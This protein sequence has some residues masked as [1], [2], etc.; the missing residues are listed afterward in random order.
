MDTAPQLRPTAA[1]TLCQT[2]FGKDPYDGFKTRMSKPDLQGWN[3][4]HGRL[5]WLVRQFK[6][7]VI[8][9]VGVWKGQ[10]TISFAKAQREVCEDGMVVAVDTF[11]G[12]PEHWNPERKDVFSSLR[13]MNGRPM[14]YK[15]FIANVQ[16]TGFADQ[17]VP[18]AQ[19]SENAAL[20]LARLGVVPDLVHIDAAHEYGPALRDIETYW[21][22][23]RPGGILAGDDFV[24]PGVARA[25]VHFSDTVKR[26]F[27][28]DSPKWWIEKP[29]R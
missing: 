24:W 23:L 29:A 20:I 27:N 8:V 16:L 18:L 19:T 11:L 5:A 4:L 26:P 9:D 22:L 10:S 7:K 6:P 15:T 1:Q 25:V 14:V 17:I 3:G 13:F 2:L 28:V 21:K 12:S